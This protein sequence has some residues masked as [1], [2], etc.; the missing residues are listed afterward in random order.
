MTLSLTAIPRTASKGERTRVRKEDHIP[1]VVYGHGIASQT[2]A[3]PRSDFEKVFREAGESTLV[4]LSLQGGAPVQTLIQDVHRHPTLGTIQHVD[5]Y[6]VRMNEK[7]SNDVPLVFTGES[8]A[9]KA[10]GGI[11]VKNI[12]TLKITCLPADLPS[13]LTV[14]IR[15]LENFES[16]ITVADIPLPK[17]VTLETKAEEIIAVVEAPRT[18]DELKALD[19]KVEENV[20]AVQ[21]VEKP[22][23]AEE[24][25]VVAAPGAEAAPAKKA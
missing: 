12:D 1:A 3:V 4:T 15:R 13:E 22:V 8:P 9:V 16:R 23:G 20:E 19:E 6:Q 5:F 24:E 21:K 10:L 11:L 14:D 25:A 2:I 18:E 17:G 7:I